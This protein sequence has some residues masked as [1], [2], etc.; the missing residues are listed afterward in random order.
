MAI[1]PKIE[2]SINE[3][4]DLVET[5]GEY[6]EPFL[7]NNPSNWNIQPLDE[8]GTIEASCGNSHEYFKGDIKEFNIRL[9]G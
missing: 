7:E 4:N 9:R 1:S 5:V 3:E 2:K 8:E 6:F